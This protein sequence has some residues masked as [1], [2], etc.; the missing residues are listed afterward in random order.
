M[1]KTKDFNSIGTGPQVLAL[2]PKYSLKL[3]MALVLPTVTG[4]L[5]IAHP[6]YISFY[7]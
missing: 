1:N 3:W 6:K 4:I 5:R 7:C 2:Q